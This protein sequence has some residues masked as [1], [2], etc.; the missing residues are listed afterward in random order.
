MSNHLV[1][2]DISTKE[3]LA[4]KL[5]RDFISELEWDAFTEMRD[6]WDEAPYINYTQLSDVLGYLCKCFS[7]E[8]YFTQIDMWLSERL[9]YHAE[10][11]GEE[12]VS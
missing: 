10:K 9:R 4:A 11:S 8:G 2:W 3:E 5:G 7:W 6:N 12:A 1:D